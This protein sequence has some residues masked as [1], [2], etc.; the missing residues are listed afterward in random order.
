LRACRRGIEY[1][2]I[3]LLIPEEFMYL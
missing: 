1:G 2:R 3:M